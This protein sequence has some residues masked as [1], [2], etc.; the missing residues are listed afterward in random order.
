MKK[1]FL[2]I[3]LSFMLLCAVPVMATCPPNEPDCCP[4]VDVDVDIKNSKIQGA[5]GDGNV[6]IQSNGAIKDNFINTGDT[7]VNVDNIDVDVHSKTWNKTNIHNKTINKNKTLNVDIDGNVQLGHQEGKNNTA[8][9]GDN[10]GIV[11]QSTGGSGYEGEEGSGGNITAI[12]DNSVVQVEDKR[13]F[14]SQPMVTFGSLGAYVESAERGANFQTVEM[15]T[16]FKKVFSYEAALK[17]YGKKYGKGKCETIGHSY[18]GRHEDNPSKEIKVYT[19]D[20]KIDPS[21]VKSI[22]FLT[23][24]SI[25]KNIN[26]F[27]VLQKAVLSACYM[28]ADAIVVTKQ[29]AETVTKSSGWGIGFNTSGATIAE[30][31]DRG[32]SAV[33]S[34]GTGYSNGTGKLDCKPWLTCQVLIFK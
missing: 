26:S 7:T 1:M 11:I 10:N 31:G 17:N 30:N 15:L 28:Q 2:A 32:K 19:L 34:G 8:I 21:T 16:M 5:I 25:H 22:G 27:M 23:I 13:E 14:L 29:G 4:L 18:N 6:G 20:D 24:K 9:N 3:C 12:V 33:A